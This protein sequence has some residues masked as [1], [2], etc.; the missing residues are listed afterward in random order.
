MSTTAEFSSDGN[1]Q[2]LKFEVELP[3]WAVDELKVTPK[4]FPTLEERMAVVNRFARLNVQHNTGGPF[5]AAV[6]QKDTGKLI[7]IGVNRVV[8][9]NCSSAHAEVVAIT[10]AQQTL[11]TFDLGGRNL[12]EH[13]LV[14]NWTPCAMCYGAVLWSGVR[15]MV[16][17]GFGDELE[18]ITG[19]DEGPRPADWKG[20]YEKRGVE[21][22]LD[23]GRQ[24]SLEVFEYFRDS[25]NLVYNARSGEI[26]T[27]GVSGLSETSPHVTTE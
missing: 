13:Q 11:G 5:A 10:L 4:T 22:I 19:F 18:E 25:G 21:V 14:V 20:E 27:S 15:S 16:A 8:H 6:V 24:E 23:V 17:A 26:E 2:A 12:P 7:A 1:G 9:S 3:P